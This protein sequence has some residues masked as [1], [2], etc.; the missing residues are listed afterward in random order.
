MD[1][2]ESMIMVVDRDKL[3][4]DYLFDGFIEHKK[5]DYEKKILENFKYMK[6]GLAEKDSSKKQPIAYAI[7]AN[8]KNKKI[9]VYQRS[10]SSKDHG[11]K[12]LQNKWSWGVGGHIERIDESSQNPIVHSMLREIK[13]EVD[14]SG[15]INTKILGYINDDSNDVG[16][17]HFGILYLVETDG[18]VT[19]KSKE[20]KR[21]KMMDLEEIERICSS[22]NVESWSRIALDPLKKMMK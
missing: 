22:Y 5:I 8:K 4:S 17:V 9:F 3:F 12:R 21:G 20:L 6:R 19:P 16:K 13:E 10:Q 18:A 1:K 15:K 7:I 11:D 14:I 2:N